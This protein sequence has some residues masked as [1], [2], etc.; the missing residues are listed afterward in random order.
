VFIFDHLRRWWQDR[1]GEDETPFDGDTPAWIVSFGIHLGLLVI[2]TLVWIFE[3]DAP[4]Q[5][6][7]SPTEEIEPEVVQ[8]FHFAKDP[9]EE[10]GAN[11]IAGTTTAMAL[12]P[13]LSDVSDVPTEIQPTDNPKLEVAVNLDIATAPNLSTDMMVKGAV[14]EGVSGAWGAID[15]ITHEILLSLAERK[16]LVVWLFDQSGSLNRTRTTIYERFDRIYHELGYIEKAGHEAFQKHDDKPLLTSVVAFGKEF[17]FRTPE[18]TDDLAE[19]KAAIKAIENDDTG[20]ENVFTAI[21]KSVERYQ[22]YRNTPPRRNVMF[23]VVSDEVGDDERFLEPCINLCQR[24]EIPVYVIGVPAPFGRRELLVKF[25]DPDP[26]YDQSVQWIPVRQGPESAM[27]ERLQLAFGGGRDEGLDELDSGF[28]PFALTRLCYETGGIY[29]AV[30]PNNTASSRAR[31]RQWDTEVMSARLQYFFDPGIMRR[32]RPDYIT[33]QEYQT[34]L[35]ENKA[36]A[37]L[38]QAAEKSRLAP[39]ENPQLV[40]PKQ[41]EGALK[42]LLD[43]AQK[44]AAKLEPRIDDL[45]NILKL[46]EKDRARLTQPRWQAGYDL[47]YGRVL[48]IKVRTETYNQMLADLKGGKNF[49]NPNSDT[50]ILRPA[51]NT[52]GSSLEKMAMQARQLLESVIREHPGTP[53]ALLAQKELETPLGWEWTEAHTGVNDPRPGDGNGNA[54]EPPDRLNRLNKPLPRRQN[55][56]L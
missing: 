42:A 56:K 11:S 20:V 49:K 18:P 36:K 16:T 44:A 48:A 12:A 43:E 17:S 31:G 9:L 38:V 13:N 35:M 2:L 6:V 50:W 29:F 8:E 54:N 24:N 45:Y 23:V 25:V 19:I 4:V 51:N 52:I 28:G 27:P 26:H 32:Y 47:E 21:G 14:G 30:H 39:M 33:I 46:G 7:L 3:K 41:N 15:R 55:V 22:K 34:Q 40:F 1:T 37:A 5:L 10:I 53:W